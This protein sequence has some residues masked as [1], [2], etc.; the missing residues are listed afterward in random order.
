RISK[1]VPCCP[2]QTPSST[3]TGIKVGSNINTTM[4][5]Q[6]MVAECKSEETRDAPQEE[7][8]EECDALPYQRIEAPNTPLDRRSEAHNAQVVYRPGVHI[9][10]ESGS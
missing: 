1:L 8:M 7:S 2:N 4:T 9:T 3:I 10:E 6:A 5:V